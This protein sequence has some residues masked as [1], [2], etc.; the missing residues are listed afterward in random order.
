MCGPAVIW[1]LSFTSRPGRMRDPLP[2]GVFGRTEPVSTVRRRWL[3]MPPS[4]LALSSVLMYALSPG[5]SSVPVPGWAP[6]RSS[7][8]RLRFSR[9]RSSAADGAVRRSVPV[10]SRNVRSSRSASRCYACPRGCGA[11]PC[12][13]QTPQSPNRCIPAAAGRSVGTQMVTACIWV[14]A[15][16][17][18]GRLSSH[19]ADVSIASGP[20]PHL[21][22]S[23]GTGA[24]SSTALGYIPARAGRGR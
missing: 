13:D 4:A 9:Q 12:S 1:L 18:G 20:S 24:C 6:A 21:R 17:C 5:L 10:A 15:R 19:T 16:L 11:P 2:T 7:R 8:R 3:P 14:E 22:G 23:M